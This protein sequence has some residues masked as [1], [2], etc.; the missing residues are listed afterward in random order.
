MA[1]IPKDGTRIV[2]LRDITSTDCLYTKRV[3]KLGLSGFF[4]AVA[5]YAFTELE[6]R[7]L[8]DGDLQQ[9]RLTSAWKDVRKNCSEVYDKTQGA[10]DRGVLATR[11]QNIL[12]DLKLDRKV[13]EKLMEHGIDARDDLYAV[14]SKER[15]VRAMINITNH[16]AYQI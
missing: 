8:N 11:G 13:A 7:Q 5:D 12:D 14:E 10:Y 2:S 16:S 6:G 9:L 3:D 4:D 15:A 1:I